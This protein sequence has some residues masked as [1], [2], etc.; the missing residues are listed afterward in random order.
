[1][2]GPYRRWLLDTGSLTS[3]LQDCCQAF[4]VERVNQYWASPGRDEA[5]LLGM[6]GREKAL[7]REVCLS[8]D[9]IPVVFAHSV[10]PRSSLRG[11]WRALGTLGSRPLGAALFANPRVARTPFGYRK[12]SPHHALYRRVVL[13]MQGARPSILWARRSVFS[14]DG[15][16]IMVTEVFLPGVLAL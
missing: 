3:R 15:A 5:S 10:L 2:A 16:A 7:L 13:L 14:L 9:G 12:L 11:K 4:A 1:M 8:C 6:H